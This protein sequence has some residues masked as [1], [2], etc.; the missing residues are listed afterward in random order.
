MS[1]GAGAS[2]W[3]QRDTHTHACEIVLLYCT[4]ARRATDAPCTLLRPCSF[5]VG[6]WPSY[7]LLTP[8]LVLLLGLGLLFSAHFLPSF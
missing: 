8:G 6:L 7:G 1:P 3:E 5:T 4:Q 2:A